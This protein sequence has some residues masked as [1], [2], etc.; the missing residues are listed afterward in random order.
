LNRGDAKDA[1][2]GNPESL[3]VIAAVVTMI[4]GYLLFVY[5]QRPQ[6]SFK[7]TV[8]FIRS[9]H[10]FVEAR[11]QKGQPLPASVQLRELV[12]SGHITS[13]VARRFDGSD[14]TFPRR[15]DVSRPQEPL[16]LKS[17][18]E[19]ILIRVRLHDGREITMSS[20]GSIQRLPR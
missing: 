11:T 17:A 18:A 13:D 1:E 7:E 2:A 19:E 8:T 9:V 4:C 16:P 10:A 20:D 14:V 3:F 12:D 5:L 6:P 15:A